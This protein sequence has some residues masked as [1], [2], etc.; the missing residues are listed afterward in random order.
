M[1]TG[2]AADWAAVP[3]E[4]PG[5]GGAVRGCC[6]KRAG[7]RQVRGAEGDLLDV[8]RNGGKGGGGS[9]VES[10]VGGCGAGRGGGKNSGC[11]VVGR[12]DLRFVLHKIIEVLLAGER[13]DGVR[14]A[15]GPN[16]GL[17]WSVRS[18]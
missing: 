1:V 18:I 17:G 16:K 2:G 3:G 13:V 15:H 10:V 8:A 5:V 12:E 11:E 7:G 6:W 4:Q 9:H 14:V